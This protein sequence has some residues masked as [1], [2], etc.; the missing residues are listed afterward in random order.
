MKHFVG[1]ESAQ[2]NL[3]SDGN[4]TTFLWLHDGDYTQGYAIADWITCI[5][6]EYRIENEEIS[7]ELRFDVLDIVNDE[8]DVHQLFDYPEITVSATARPLFMA[9]REKYAEALKRLDAIN[10]IEL[11]D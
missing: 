9:I 1:S 6:D 3:D 10:F 8:I 7:L 2:F 5:I 11:P 4:L